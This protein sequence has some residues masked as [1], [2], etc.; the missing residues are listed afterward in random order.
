MSIFE[1]R[2]CALPITIP[3]DWTDE[4][5]NEVGT[6]IRERDSLTVIQ[7]FRPIG[8]DIG[9]AKGIFLH[10]TRKKGFCHHCK[11][12]LVEYEGKC[13]KCKRLNLDW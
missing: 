9:Q 4:K 3:D 12:E 10:V 11:T 13:P 7:Y 1:C 2:K 8:M 6:L 5:K